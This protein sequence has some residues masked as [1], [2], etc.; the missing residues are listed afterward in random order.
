MQNEFNND[1]NSGDDRYLCKQALSR[2]VLILIIFESI[3]TGT[4]F[5][6]LIYFYIMKNYKEQFTQFT[7]FLTEKN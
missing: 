3:F 1:Y 5:L 7:N 4:W 2:S 6:A